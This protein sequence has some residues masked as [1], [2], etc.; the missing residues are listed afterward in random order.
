[1]AQ[2]AQSKI[3][4]I[5]LND[6]DRAAVERVIEFGAEQ[7]K[8]VLIDQK[9]AQADIIIA[10]DNATLDSGTASIIRV[11]AAKHHPSD[12]ILTPPLLVSKVMRAIDQALERSVT[13]RGKPL[14]SREAVTDSATKVINEP[15]EDKHSK[16]DVD[17][18]AQGETDDQTAKDTKPNERH[19]GHKAEYTALV[20]DD[21]AA[22]RKQ[23]ELEL[24]IAKINVEFAKSGEEALSQCT[25]RVYDLIFLDII[26]PGID[27]YKVC[28]TLRQLSQYK[29]VPIIMLSGKTSPLDE[30]QGVIAGASTYLT[31]PIKHKQF[32]STL[33]RIS[34]WL[35]E[36]SA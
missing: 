35:R 28:E 8:Y 34:N 15:I 13:P 5:G 12:F 4:I 10:Q 16:H 25:E 24:R 27:G 31:K 21:S 17:Q 19:A 22:I 9:P 18:Y 30:V 2:P 14:D 32:Q 20:V 23:L 26:M 33:G 6:N 7:G 3:C 29:K 11:G 36:F 1:M